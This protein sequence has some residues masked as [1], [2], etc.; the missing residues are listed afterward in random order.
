MVNIQIIDSSSRFALSR[1]RVNTMSRYSALFT[2]LH[3]DALPSL[4][5]YAW[6]KPLMSFFC[7]RAAYYRFECRQD[8]EASLRSCAKQGARNLA[9]CYIENGNEVWQGVLEKVILYEILNQPFDEKNRIKWY[10]MFL[11]SEDKRTLL[12]VSNNG[13]CFGAHYLS[14]DDLTTLSELLSDYPFSFFYW[15]NTK[16]GDLVDLQEVLGDEELLKQLFKDM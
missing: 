2:F 14:R 16:N 8:Q 5:D 15:E 6:W 4:G 11:I 9:Y 3:D 13:I 10:E 1:E 7:D 12:S